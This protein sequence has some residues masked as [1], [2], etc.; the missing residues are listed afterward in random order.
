MHVREVMIGLRGSVLQK[1]A[2]VISETE[3]SPNETS[4]PKRSLNTS[5]N[6]SRNASAVIVFGK[7]VITA[8][9]NSCCLDETFASFSWK[10]FT[11][12]AY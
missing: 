7:K 8:R 10:G 12:I 1:A 9:S 11:L 2:C 3:S 6:P 5:I 4:E